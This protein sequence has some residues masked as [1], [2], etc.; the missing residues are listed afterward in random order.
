MNKHF[1]LCKQDS[2]LFMKQQNY[3]QI[4]AVISPFP[5]HP[6]I[7]SVLNTW[8]TF[9]SIPSVNDLWVPMRRTVSA[10][11]LSHL[12]AVAPDLWYCWSCSTCLSQR[13]LIK[14]LPLGFFF[15]FIH[16]KILLEVELRKDV[17]KETVE[18]LSSLLPRDCSILRQF[19]GIS[20]VL[21]T[22]DEKFDEQLSCTVLF[23]F[24]FYSYFCF[25]V[26]SMPSSLNPSIEHNHISST[27]L[28]LKNCRWFFSA[29]C[30][31][32]AFCCCRAATFFLLP[33]PGLFR[34]ARFL[35][36]HLP[37]VLKRGIS[38]QKNGVLID[39][40]SRSREQNR[41]GFLVC[42]SCLCPCSAL[43]AFSLW[44][45]QLKYRLTP[46]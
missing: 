8:F 36:A 4:P 9:F 6:V 2:D 35:A 27:C 40:N 20:L 45:G 38:A 41:W 22:P 33:T 42:I 34:G 11:D 24:F 44:V 16:L 14:I 10:V 37:L 18:A 30:W 15:F 29:P 43:S 46:T 17:W 39:R 31:Y 19:S 23:V 28:Y 21:F 3:E 13:N 12:S 5:L 25:T 26:V 7:I 32:V 1:L